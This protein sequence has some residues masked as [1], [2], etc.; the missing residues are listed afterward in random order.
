[1]KE[2]APRFLPF[3]LYVMMFVA[4]A[5]EAILGGSNYTTALAARIA[6]AYDLSDPQ[7][8]GSTNPHERFLPLIDTPSRAIRYTAADLPEI[9]VT[10]LNKL[11]LRTIMPIEQEET[12]CKRS[13]R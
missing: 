3:G 2:S 11:Q 9:P 6:F 4:V 1:L 7:T 10:L 13:R 5:P 8:C 12:D